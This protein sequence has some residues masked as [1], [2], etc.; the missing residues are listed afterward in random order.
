MTEKRAKG[1]WQEHN[2]NVGGSSGHAGKDVCW[3]EVVR[4]S[5][6]KCNALNKM[7]HEGLD[8]AVIST[9]EV[10][11]KTLHKAPI[12]QEDAMEVHHVET[13]PPEMLQT[14]CGMRGLMALS[15]AP[16]RL[17]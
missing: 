12:T 15:Q 2:A 11:K 14:K 17:H 10:A 7:K 1:P 8:G 5:N 6:I 13:V 9:V 4:Q 16:W 3:L